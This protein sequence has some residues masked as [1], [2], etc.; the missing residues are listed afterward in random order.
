NGH[1]I[2]Y[3][4]NV[5]INMDDACEWTYGRGAYAEV[6]PNN[7]LAFN[8][9]GFRHLLLGGLNL[10]AYCQAHGSDGSAV[11]NGRWICYTPTVVIDLNDAC[12]W[13]YGAEAHAQS[14]PGKPLAV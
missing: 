9:Y 7:P 4:P 6:E 10:D 1:W 8:C 13:S 5:T 14:E 2:C 3:T 12:R 11:R